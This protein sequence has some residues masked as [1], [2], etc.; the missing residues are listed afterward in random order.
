M[1]LAL[2]FKESSNDNDWSIYPIGMNDISMTHISITDMIKCTWNKYLVTGIDNNVLSEP[3]LK[4][5]V[6][7]GASLSASVAL[8]FVFTHIVCEKGI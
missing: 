3:M 6:V 8:V 7:F 4:K 1:V 5:D 2:Y